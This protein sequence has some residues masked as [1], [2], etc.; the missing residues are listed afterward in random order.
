MYLGSP[1]HVWVLHHVL[2]N[3][4]RPDA[5][6]SGCSAVALLERGA[7]LCPAAPAVGLAG[8][9]ALARDGIGCTDFFL[10]VGIRF[11]DFPL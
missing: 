8:A 7:H 4:I 6:A 5:F 2:G 3:G 9:S 11:V 1:P 10:P